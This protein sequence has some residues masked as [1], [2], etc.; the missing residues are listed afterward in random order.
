MVRCKRL[1]R[2]GLGMVLAVVLLLGSG[3]AGASGSGTSGRRIPA[4]S[5]PAGRCPGWH[6]IPSPSPDALTNTLNGVAAASPTAAWAVG[7][8]RGSALIERW[9]GRSWSLVPNPAAGKAQTLY[10]VSAISATDVWAVGGDATGTLTEHWDGQQ[11]RVVPSPNPAG[12]AGLDAVTAVPGSGQVWAVGSYLTS[13]QTSATLIEQWNGT[14]W[15]LVSSPNGGTYANSLDS[16]AALAATD[17]WAGG[18]T[19]TNGNV[20]PSQVLLERWDGQQWQVVP[21][22]NPGAFHN[23]VQAMVTI[24]GTA[25]LWAVGLSTNSALGSIKTLT[26][27]YC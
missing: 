11:W 21:G 22:P 25:S 8:A 13:T 1:L 18:G 26:E 2:P 9:S 12:S 19:A 17:V 5:I 7:Q 23:Q 15:Q 3:T 20:S 14:A 24:P 27:L 6:V 16:V 10:G 4:T